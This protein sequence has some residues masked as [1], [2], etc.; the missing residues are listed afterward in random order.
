MTETTNNLPQTTKGPKLT[1]KQKLFIDNLQHYRSLKKAARAAGYSSKTAHN[2][3]QHIK[4]CPNLMKALRTF[5]QDNSVLL[6]H[7][8]SL[9]DK[10]I[11][12]HCKQPK[13]VLNVPKFTH[14]LKQI[15]QAAGV[16]ADD[17]TPKQPTISIT[18]IEKVQVA[19]A[20]MLTKR[21]N[22]VS[23]SANQE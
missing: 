22:G 7:D 1:D 20:G 21:L 23:S 11:I 13:N 15:K 18:H 4:A 3:T 10:S 17:I 12:D 2:I 14:S 5:Y 6:L 9:I 8:M 19:V 16:L